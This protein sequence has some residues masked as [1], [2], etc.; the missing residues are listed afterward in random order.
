MKLYFHEMLFRYVVCEMAAILFRPRCVYTF[1][2]WKPVKTINM[3]S[4]HDLLFGVRVYELIGSYA[5]IKYRY[6]FEN[7]SFPSTEYPV[8]KAG[9]LLSDQD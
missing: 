2:N 8:N 1:C 9:L 3:Y 5:H 4:H 6:E 7:V